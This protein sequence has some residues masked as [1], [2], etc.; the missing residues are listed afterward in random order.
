MCDKSCENCFLSRREFLSTTAGLALALAGCEV[1]GK[2]KQVPVENKKSD[3][4]KEIKEMDNLKYVTY[5]GLYCGLCTAR[6]RIPKQAAALRDTMANDG[7]DKWGVNIPDFKEF[8]KFLNEHCEPD[9]N[10]PGCRQG[11]GPPF[12]SIRK[13]AT[14]KKIDLCVYCDEYPC[15]RIASIAKGYP[16]LL[17]DGKRIKEIGID[18]WIAEQQQR[19]KT[20][21]AY[22]DIRCYPY[23]VPEK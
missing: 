20:G 15:N 2:S 9:K 13:C 4:G 5:C 22:A 10:C 3:T 14:A 12:C 6:C 21:F 16:T 23:T 1:I 7:Y 19:A 18:K 17:A 11:G 8:W